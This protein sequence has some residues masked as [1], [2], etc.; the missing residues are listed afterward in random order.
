MDDYPQPSNVGYADDV[1]IE[2]PDVIPP[3]AGSPGNIPT[4]IL[5]ATEIAYH[6][7]E[8]DVADTDLAWQDGA[9]I[10]T[11]LVRQYLVDR[12]YTVT[13]VDAQLGDDGLPTGV[14]TVRTNPVGE[15]IFPLITFDID[16]VTESTTTA[17]VTAA[18]KIADT[19]IAEL[20]ENVT[21]SGEVT[22]SGDLWRS[23]DTGDMGIVPVLEGVDD[24]FV[25]IAADEDPAPVS[26]TLPLAGIVGGTAPEF[27]LKYRGAST[28]G[29]THIA[30]AQITGWLRDGA[31]EPA[32]A[33]DPG[34]WAVYDGSR[35]QPIL[36]TVVV[37][38]DTNEGAITLKPDTDRLVSLWRYL[39]AN[40]VE[41][42]QITGGWNFATPEAAPSDP[43]LHVYARSAVDPD[44]T[45]AYQ[46][47]EIVQADRDAFEVQWVAAAPLSTLR[48][49][50]AGQVARPGQDDRSSPYLFSQSGEP[51]GD[52][53]DGDQWLK[54]PTTNVYIRVNDE[55]VLFSTTG[56]AITNQNS[57]SFGRNSQADAGYATAGGV[58]ALANG[59]ASSAYGNHSS[60]T[61]EDSAAFGADSTSSG[62]RSAAYGRNS[63][64][65]GLLSSS[66]GYGSVA[67]GARS[68]ANG[69]SSSATHTRS[70][71]EGYFS[72][73]IADDTK[74]LKVNDEVQVPSNGTG[75]TRKGLKSP[76]AAT[77]WISVDNS[78]KLLID[79]AN[80]VHDAV[81]VTDSTSVDLTLTGQ[82]VTAAV[83][84][85][86][87]GGTNGSAATA[88]RSDHSHSQLHDAV[89]VTDSTSVD[90]T[91]TGQ[92][93]T[94]AVIYAGT[95]TATTAARSDHF[96][97]VPMVAGTYYSTVERGFGS[98]AAATAYVMPSG[99]VNW[100][101]I[102]I[103][104]AMA[105]DRIGVWIQAAV[106]SSAVRLGIFTYNPTTG[107]MERVLD[108]GA[109][110]GTATG[111]VEATISI[112]LQPGWYWLG[113]IGSNSPS[114]RL[115]NNGSP[116]GIST[117][118]AGATRVSFITTGATYG[119]WPSTL[120]PNDQSTGLWA[121]ALRA[122]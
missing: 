112:T 35:Y 37:W 119:A 88:A 7:Y 28:A 59:A 89:T 19:A 122:A 121:V 102:F 44:L 118:T 92:N 20:P 83:K 4:G 106:A 26:V 109:V 29:T 72:A 79:D 9:P 43:E 104:H 58:D 6:E 105:F 103:P 42:Q 57:A 96:H 10:D 14:L 63:Q 24:A 80:P 50:M 111:L 94:A 71:V 52:V 75:R 60:A 8:L 97:E 65:I 55:W 110:V 25:S 114:V 49:K 91:L 15:S 45:D 107:N 62:E 36:E 3:S 32:E 41:V 69:A 2:P 100:S 5:P 85:A 23:V 87:S 38:T 18:S 77:H 12:G 90:L 1:P 51:T 21:F 48:R 117:T 33:I 56:V 74:T 73:S 81:T 66:H 22:F 47:S 31:T 108:A 64:A 98:T 113:M 16:D 53:R 34:E 46:Y 99:R 78:G 30:N 27:G 67:S 54:T 61:G 70:V 116:T 84:Y 13:S 39:E 68:T 76:D 17:I 93:V 86:G 115:H 95:G 120:A 40:G 11:G 101:G 82:D